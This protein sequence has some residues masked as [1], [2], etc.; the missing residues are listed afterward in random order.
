MKIGRLWYYWVAV[1]SLV[2]S[3]SAFA[4]ST[5]RF[6]LGLGITQVIDEFG[7]NLRHGWKGCRASIGP[8][9]RWDP[10][11]LRDIW[12]QRSFLGFYW[13]MILF[14]LD[15]VLFLLMQ[16]WLGVGFHAFICFACFAVS[17]H[18]AN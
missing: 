4:G 10:G 7:R 14:A 1:L 5:W 12:Q 13:G 2:N 9:C 15:G 16:D 17:R 3:V 8:A 11:A 18:A 6:I